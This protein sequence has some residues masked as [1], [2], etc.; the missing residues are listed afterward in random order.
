MTRDNLTHAQKDFQQL[1]LKLIAFPKKKRK[2]KIIQQ[3]KHELQPGNKKM[4]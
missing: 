4:Q 3:R 2:A 1:I